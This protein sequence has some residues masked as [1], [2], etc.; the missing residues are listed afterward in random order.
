MGKKQSS[1][2]A[3]AS[4]WYRVKETSFIGEALREQGDYV[5]FDGDAGS[6]LEPVSEDEVRQAG[7]VIQT[8]AVDLD[9]REIDLDKREKDIVGREKAVQLREKELNDLVEAADTRAKELDDRE[10]AVAAREALA[11]A[12]KK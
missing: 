4:N 6:N 5:Q 3:S 8:P 9:S 10:A 7:V 1:D 2:G 12:D 11:P